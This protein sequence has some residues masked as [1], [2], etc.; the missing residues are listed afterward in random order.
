MR[1]KKVGESRSEYLLTVPSVWT[2]ESS[3]MPSTH[4]ITAWEAPINILFA[5]VF[6]KAENASEAVTIENLL[7]T[8]A[9]EGE[10]PLPIV[11]LGFRKTALPLDYRRSNRA[12]RRWAIAVQHLRGSG[13]VACLTLC[14]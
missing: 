3:P 9:L 1:H 12:L 8:K 7:R 14:I 6:G 13:D 5:E 10:I 2:E 11:V 4:R